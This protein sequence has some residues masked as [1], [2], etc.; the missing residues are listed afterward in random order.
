MG[1]TSRGI[2]RIFVFEGLMVALIGTLLGCAGG[3]TLGYVLDKYELIHLPGDV[4]FIETL[5]VRM[6]T[7]DFVLI[8]LG[9]ILI[10]LLASLYPARRASRM[11]PIEAIR[12]E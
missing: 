9:A 3:F 12:Y 8:P 4:Y 5:P 11:D 10:C 2:M 7:A 6:Q 1:A